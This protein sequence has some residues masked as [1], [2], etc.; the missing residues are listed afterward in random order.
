MLTSS[1][2]STGS[3]V[4]VVTETLGL[5]ADAQAI[6]TPEGVT[7][8]VE[9]HVRAPLGKLGPALTGA[10]AAL[11]DGAQEEQLIALTTEAEG[12]TAVLK[13]NMMLRRLDQGG[14]LRHTVS[15]DGVPL[16]T[17]Q[18]VGHVMPPQL[19]PAD[20][21]GQL[22]LSRFACLR[23][24]NGVV[25]VES[26]LHAVFV[27]L[28]DPA[29]AGLVG[30]LALPGQ[31]SELGDSVPGLA[32]AAIRPILRLLRDAAV[33]RAAGAPEPPG[34][35]QWSFADLMFH[36]RSRVGRNLGGF[37]GTY[38]RQGLAEPLPAVKPPRAPALV[39]PTPDLAAVTAEDPPFGVVLERRRSI[40]VHDDA[41]PITVSELGELLYRAARVRGVMHDGHQELS[42]RPYPGGGAC[43]ELEIYPLVNLCAGVSP[44]LYHYDPQA[45]TLGL[46]AQ[47]GPPTILLSEY[48]RMTAVMD[49][50]PQ[51]ALLISARFGRVMWKYE[52]MA[53]ALVLKQ[54]GVLYQTLY[55]TATAMGLAPC[56]LGGG[57]S[58][59]F[60]TAAGCDFYEETS[61]GEF[62]IGRAAADTSIGQAA[63]GAG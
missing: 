20:L 30:R 44:G 12:E 36:A 23:A 5:R 40:R 21:A 56:A 22:V 37:G 31:A 6:L 35:A 47:P 48:S 45:H 15:V 26:P 51:V 17:R 10:V 24:D 58:D 25:R 18:P 57:N 11:A 4:A 8:L 32:P 19:P 60:C 41:N 33:V 39:L 54:V 53:Y 3:E 9:G 34:Q 55:L 1:P 14:W 38:H 16:A 46:V 59:A 52:S 42:S 61:V 13:L 29:L 2:P 7:A 43:Y 62:I 27:E 63:Q 49:A 28:H 50:T